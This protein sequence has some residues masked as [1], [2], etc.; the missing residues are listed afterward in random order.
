MPRWVVGHA[1][2]GGDWCLTRIADDHSVVT[3]WMNRGEAGQIADEIYR[4]CSWTPYPERINKLVDE[5]G[6]LERTIAGLRGALK[7]AGRR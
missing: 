1:V 4:Q 6:R 5:V 3:W 7:R 2:N